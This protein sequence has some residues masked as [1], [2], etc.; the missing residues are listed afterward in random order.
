[1]TDWRFYDTI[2]TERYMKRPQD[3]EEGYEDSAPLNFVEGLEAPFLLIHGTADDN[4][5]L[6][7]SIRLV[8][9]LIDND[10]DFELML[11]PGKFHGISGRADQI[12]LYKQLTRFFETT[13]GPMRREPS[14]Y[15]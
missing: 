4:V 5:H 10:K 8:S 14:T 13:I 2:Y 3:N 9:E 12:H 11:Y 1:M 15:P 7:N 6:Q